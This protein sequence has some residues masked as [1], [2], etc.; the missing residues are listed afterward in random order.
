MAVGREQESENRL[1][2]ESCLETALLDSSPGQLSWTALRW[3][4]PVPGLKGN[5]VKGLERGREPKGPRGKGG[6]V[7]PLCSLL[8][9]SSRVMC[10]LP[11]GHL[12][13]AQDFLPLGLR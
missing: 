13:T 4:F 12:I 5:G 11:W 1:S 9:R 8:S 3:N 6:Q 2:G 10:P 7:A